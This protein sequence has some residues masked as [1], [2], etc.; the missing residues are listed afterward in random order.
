MSSLEALW[1]IRFDAP[2]GDES[3]L[4]SGVVIFETGRVFGGDAG[5]AY[6]GT[7]EVDGTNIRGA[8][9]ILRHDPTIHSIFGDGE[10]F[11]ITFDCERVSDTRMEGRFTYSAGKGGTLAMTRLVDLPSCSAASR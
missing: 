11:Q 4:R 3:N 10:D 9:R 2:G 8:A 1:T 5:Y 6:V 7:F